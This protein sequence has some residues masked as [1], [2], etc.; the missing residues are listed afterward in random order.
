MH[1]IHSD[2]KKNRIYIIL[3]GFISL[4]EAKEIEEKVIIN[5]RKLSHGFSAIADTL[6][7][8]PA[9]SEV[10]IILEKMI[11]I[12]KVYGL[13]NFVKII[14]NHFNGVQQQLFFQNSALANEASNLL[15]AERIL[16]KY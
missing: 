15:S 9:N 13:N 8:K 10:N 16:D 14:G 2:I 5:V 11:N 4:E 12:L 7:T 6:D 1:K 3:K